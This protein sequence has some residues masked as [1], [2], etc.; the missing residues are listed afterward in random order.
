MPN[1]NPQS[2]P[3]PLPGSWLAAFTDA[4]NLPRVTIP[5]DFIQRFTGTAQGRRI[6]VE[7]LRSA[8]NVSAPVARALLGV[9]SGRGLLT[10]KIQL[11]CANSDCGRALCEL[12]FTD[13]ILGK[14]PPPVCCDVCQAMERDV[15]EFPSA[16]CPRMDVYEVRHLTTSSS[17]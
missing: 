10:H 13:V 5:A 7:N 4:I 9:A 15:F 6:Y 2:D 11:L 3:L 1:S 12:P 17:Q 14:F 8:L 16:D